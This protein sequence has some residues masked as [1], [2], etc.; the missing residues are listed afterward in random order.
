MTE[1]ELEEYKALRATICQRGTARVWIFVAGLSAWAGLML[2]TSAVV[3]IPLLTLLPLLVL[4]GTFEAVFAL[5]VT[6]ERIGRYLLVFHEDTWEQTA[7]AFGPPLAGTGTDPLFTVFF[8]LATMCNFV[9]V[10]LA[11]P[12][13]AEIVAMGGAHALLLVRIVVARQV[14]G[15]QRSADFE[16]F[17]RIKDDAQRRTP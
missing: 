2:A 8:V 11:E 3:S 14:A 10:L 6:V 17:Q 5:H 9:P 4:A 7:T 13:S 1:R 12:V 16:R 15:R